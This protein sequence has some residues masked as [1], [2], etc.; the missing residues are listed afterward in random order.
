MS[1]LKIKKTDKKH[2]TSDSMLAHLT[3]NLGYGAVF[4]Q[5]DGFSVTYA[6]RQEMAYHTV[7]GIHTVAWATRILRRQLGGSW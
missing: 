7:H 4:I 3:S 2:H 5:G 1:R 6:L